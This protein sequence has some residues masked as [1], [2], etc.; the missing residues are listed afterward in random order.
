M[1]RNTAPAPAPDKPF[2]P[3]HPP[4]PEAGACLR[5]GRLFGDSLALALAAAA[6]DYA[7]PV[8]LVTPDMPQLE[9]LQGQLGWF[10]GGDLERL[11]FPDWETLPYDA[12]SPHQDIIS[13][14]IETLYRLPDFHQG[15]LILPVSTLMQRVAPLSYIQ[16]RGLSVKVGERLDVEAMRARFE[17]AGYT[18][19]AQVMEHG[20]FAVR[21][22]L[23]DIY[24]MGSELPYR[25]D[26]FDDEVES[27]RTFEPDSQRSIEKVEAIHLLPAREFPF[28]SDAVSRFRQA[29][30]ARFEGDPQRS[31][32]YR[33]VSQGISPNGIEYYLPLFFE[34]TASLLD[35]L[36]ADC[37][38]LQLPGCDAAAQDFWQQL[39]AR[40]D[41]YRH[42]LER[43]VLAP[44]QL[45]LGLDELERHLA[46]SRRVEILRFDEGAAEI[47][48]FATCGLPDVSL[49]PRAT[50]PA[51]QLMQF[52]D[53][54]PGRVL[55]TAES[56]GR[57]EHLL[58]SLR[59]NGLRPT[60][61]EGWQAF[62][63]SDARLAIAVAPLE[64]GLRLE[65]GTLALLT[66]TQLLGRRASQI[67][68]R[69]PARDP[70]AIIRELTDLAVG[71]PVVHEELGV[72]R[73]LGLQKLTAGGLE[74]EF[75]TLEYA[76]GDKLYVPVNS[77]HLISRYTGS[78]PE[79]A[80]L[81]KL[82]T[83]HWAKAKRKAAEKAR[84]VAA[85]LLDI[86]ARRA[87][88]QGHSFDIH[89]DEYRQFAAAFPF[90]ETPDQEQAIEAVL[91]DM[92]APQP[93]DR[94]VCGDVGFGKTEVA[95]RAAFVAATSGQQV[96][97]L[98]P[99]TLLAQQHYENFRDR[100]A[101]WPIRIEAL[102]RFRSGKQQET[103]LQQLSD[104]KVD[105]VI[106]THK[107][108]QENVKF[109]QL[110]LVIVDEEHRFGV[111]QKERLKAL[112]AEVDMLTL[113]ATPIPRT[114][115]MS[116]SGLRDLSIIATPPAQ[117]LAVKTFV[118]E[119]NDQ[120]IREACLREIKR[121]GQVYFLHNQVE[122]IDKVA[123]EL[124][125]LVPEAGIAIGHG[126]MREREL[127]QV[128]LDFYHRRFNLLVCTTIIESG[129]DVPTANTII[130]NRADKL[131]LAQLHQ[132]R[133]RVGRSHHRAY[134]Y[135]VTP[136]ARAM[137]ADAV[138]R[139]EAIASLEELGAGFSLST[140]DLEIR[141][142]G[143]LLGDEQSGQI[144][145]IGFSLYTE[146]LERAVASLKA[147]KEPQLERPLEHGAE[148]DLRI[149]ALIPDDYVPDVHGRLILYKRIANCR[150]E[151]ELR[152][153]QVEL[154]DR[155][156]LLPP[157]VKNLF[158]ITRLKLRA[159]PLGIRKIDA[160]ET[161]GRFEFTEQPQVDAARIV[162]LVQTAPANYRLDGV[163]KLRFTLDMPDAE[164]RLE[165]VARLLN[166][167]SPEAA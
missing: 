139:L 45:Y 23:L 101:D 138:K 17:Q 57:R 81:H 11:S 92:A 19:V 160:G 71:A 144:Q 89:S 158:A 151:D 20:E 33:D 166:E 155:F 88:R 120:T 26:L 28:D 55:I 47:V 78:S 116:L 106:G 132:L 122:T 91:A 161:A 141:G 46:A 164:T 99:T 126:Q 82:G 104:G 102:S 117:R 37:L 76:G 15:V 103:I 27:I 79:T 18:C 43:P 21:G 58:D 80:P 123:R 128:M 145:E 156:G 39:E 67:S 121:G 13:Q 85:E 114:L 167:I 162:Q 5:W 157:Q 56:A 70:E 3:R 110:G 130:I 150:S 10:S 84:D 159:L 25:L 31:A 61:V 49:K 38:F 129:I 87:A 127:E 6:R 118:G 148:I 147:G 100:M 16:G 22:S 133:G 95:M 137:T 53:Q 135:L 32:V 72:G 8:V 109:K 44:D 12:F 105:I 24:P 35:Y 96:A 9:Q 77:L 83:D 1:N 86:Y 69:K 73:Y 136:P 149:P 40:H 143:E 42:D 48:N 52:L 124:A 142:A 125:E 115:N 93:M 75:L 60:P 63:D 140:H 50:Q 14:R 131:G 153:L 36:P 119:W 54:H 29:W 146:L 59:D 90:E 2:D 165:T 163:E 108:L 68:R 97:L 111:R 152:E 107:L 51:E 62:L 134:A 98:V 74:N 7:G 4:L 113:T 66:E 64:Q 94:V 112:R 154:I 34:Q 30:R 41:Q 65:D